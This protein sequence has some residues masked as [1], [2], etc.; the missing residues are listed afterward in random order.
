VRI[1]IV[2]SG[3]SG[4]VAARLL[5]AVHDVVV[6]EANPRIGGHVNTVRVNIDDEQHEIDTGFIVYNERTYPNFCRIVADLAVETTPT[7]MSFS[8]RCDR[9]GLEY[10]G[11]SLN[12][13]F[14]QR[15]NLVRPSFLLM[16]RDILRFNREG[17][18]DLDSVSQEQTVGDYIAAK[19]FSRQFARQYLLPMGAAIWSCPCDA[20]AQFPIRFILEFYVNHGLLSLRDRPTW[21]VVDGGSR[22]YVDRLVEPFHDRI[23]LNCPVR[24]VMRTEDAVCVSHADGDETFDEIVFACHADQAL[25]LLDDVD[26][27]E[28]DLLSAFP[29]SMNSAVL[30]TDTSVLPK[31]QRAWASWNYHVASDEGSRPT[32]TYNMNILQHIQ[33]RHTFCVTLNEDKLVAPEKVIDRFK[34]AHPVF[35]A[36]R[37]AVQ[38]RHDELIRRR[39]TSFCGAYWRN[40]F[41]EDGVVSAL[42]VCRRFGI[43][44]WTV[45][46]PT[47]VRVSE[48][49]EPGVADR[50]S[51]PIGTERSHVG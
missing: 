20:F 25:Q 8:V 7:S 39:R 10:N 42:A 49:T 11:T 23:R 43:A 32:L 19:G 33:S 41:H 36:R 22:R 30:H 15:R 9:T 38:K 21:R 1:A 6:F 14:A 28:T 3:V 2:G 45:K 29:Y 31:R 18:E 35:S 17:P 27:L 44:N 4:L 5:S 16:L 47:A 46:V 48:N 37:S 34:Y 40:G 26:S 50:V 24:Q 13:V 12:G 51:E